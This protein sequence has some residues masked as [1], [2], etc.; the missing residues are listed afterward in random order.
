MFEAISSEPKPAE[1]TARDACPEAEPLAD[2]ASK[3]EGSALRVA[4]DEIK[5]HCVFVLCPF[6]L[7][8]NP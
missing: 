6:H 8:S 4:S 1:G 5:A 3:A 7:I 2:T